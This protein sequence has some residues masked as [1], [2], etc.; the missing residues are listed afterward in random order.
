LWCKFI[1]N[2]KFIIKT[3]PQ[4]PLNSENSKEFVS[5]GTQNGRKSENVTLYLNMQILSEI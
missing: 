2:Y 4:I 5:K 1:R 3:G